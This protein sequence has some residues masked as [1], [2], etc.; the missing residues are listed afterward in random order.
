[1]NEDGR[2]KEGENGERR[3]TDDDGVDGRDG[4]TTDGI[5]LDGKR[6]DVQVLYGAPCKRSKSMVAG[7][8]A[9]VA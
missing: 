1:V 5:E 8:T 6:V 7:R 9:S 3:Q 4:K 2:R